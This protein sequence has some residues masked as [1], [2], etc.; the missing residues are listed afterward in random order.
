VRAGQTGILLNSLPEFRDCLWLEIRVAVGAAE[1]HVKFRSVTERILHFS[2]DL[3]RTLF[4]VKVE[5]G[6][7]QVV[8]IGKGGIE[9]DG[10]F[11][12]FLCFLVPIQL[13]K[14]APQHLMGFSQPYTI[15]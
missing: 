7:G 6:N 11:Q 10:S 8:S 12:L 13:Q 5:A 4:V 1:R 9:V 2:E 15:V 3:S 14:R